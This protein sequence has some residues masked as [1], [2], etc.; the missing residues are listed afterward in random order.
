MVIYADILIVVNLIVDYFLIRITAVILRRKPP[1]WRTVAAAAVAAA[2]TLVIF[3]PQ[4]PVAAEIA[5]KAVMSAA[6]CLI[7]FGYINFRQTVF[8]AAVFFGVTFCYAGGMLALWYIFKPGGMA[9]NNSVVYF[10]V[11]PVFLVGFSALGFLIFSVISSVFSRRHKT[12]DTCLVTLEF[13]GKKADFSAVSDSGNSLCDPFFGSPVIIADAKKCAAALGE[14]SPEAYPERYRA[15]PCK[16]VSG[17]VLLDGFRCDGGSITTAGK[18]LTL[19][20]PIVALSKTPLC[21]TEAIVNPCDC[22]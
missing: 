2:G 16:T 13:C 12:A 8:A 1:L 3:L 18:T 5:E 20:R 9:I 7:A 17:R 4:L 6:V 15:I 14:L 10:D 11:S 21:D 19:N 22:D